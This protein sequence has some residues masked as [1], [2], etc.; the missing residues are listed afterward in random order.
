MVANIYC[1][2]GYMLSTMLRLLHILFYLTLTTTLGG[3]YYSSV[4]HKRTERIGNL[5]EVTQ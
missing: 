5:L 4:L 2:L 1:T 3:K